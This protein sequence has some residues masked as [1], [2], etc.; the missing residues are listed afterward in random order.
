VG[1]QLRYEFV[2]SEALSPYLSATAQYSHNG[3]VPTAPA[4]SAGTSRYQQ[5]TVESHAGQ[6]GGGAGLRFRLSSSLAL[7]G[8]GRVMYTT[9]PM[10]T[11]GT[12][13]STTQINENTRAEAVLGLTYL[14]R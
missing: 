6:F 3:A 8:E 7:F 2:A 1:A 4:G 14:F 5:L 9:Y 11:A 13:W 12:G 10:G